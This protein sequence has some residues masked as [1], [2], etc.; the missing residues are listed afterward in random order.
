MGGRSRCVPPS[1][2][3]EIT[4]NEELGPEHPLTRSVSWH[5]ALRRNMARTWWLLVLAVIAAAV[6][7]SSAIAALVGAW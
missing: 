6:T 7:G 2:D 1:G 4:L 3:T 5:R